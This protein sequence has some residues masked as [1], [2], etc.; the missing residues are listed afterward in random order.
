MDSSVA[1]TGHGAQAERIA[2]RLIP[3]SSAHHSPIQ[4]G[5]QEK[6]D[7]E[8]RVVVRTE[9]NG[10]RSVYAGNGRDRRRAESS[11]ST[12]VEVDPRA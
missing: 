3:L 6:D 7:V 4:R 11:T 1:S 9:D 8:T 5:S 10:S 12:P 2:N